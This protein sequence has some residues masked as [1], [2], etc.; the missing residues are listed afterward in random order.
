MSESGGRID[1]P[2]LFSAFRF[3][4]NQIS[5]RSYAGVHSEKHFALGVSKHLPCEKALPL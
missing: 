3:P 5:V 2:S 4:E 1:P